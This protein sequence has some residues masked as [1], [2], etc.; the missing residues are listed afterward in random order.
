MAIDTKPSSEFPHPRFRL[1]Y[2]LGPARGST[3]PNRHLRT[4][5]PATADA[6]YC[7]NESIKYVC[8]GAKM[9]IMP[10]P[11][12]SSPMMGTTQCAFLYVAQPYQKSEMGIRK[13]KN[14]HCGPVSLRSIYMSVSEQGSRLTVGSR[15]S[16][17]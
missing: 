12:G 1:S 5:R 4:V 9:P 16:G 14:T 15:I 13:P 8:T 2:M 7:G 11:K 17:S 3:A 6:A 10:Q